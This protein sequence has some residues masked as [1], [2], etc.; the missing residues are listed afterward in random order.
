MRKKYS[1]LLA[2]LFIASFLTAQISGSLYYQ[3][4]YAIK[5]DG[6]TIVGF[7][8]KRNDVHLSKSVNYKETL[9]IDSPTTFLAAD[10]N[11]LY[12]EKGAVKY[13]Q[14]EYLATYNNKTSREKRLAK[15]LLSGYC[16]LYQLEIG[17]KEKPFYF[18]GGSEFVYVVKKDGQWSQLSETE[19][20]EDSQYSLTKEYINSLR[21]LFNDCDAIDEEVIT[22]INFSAQDL[23][24]LFTIYNNCKRNSSQ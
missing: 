4:G 21:T 24:R 18:E 9:S 8:Q 16:N 11:C 14:V 19:K 13:E 15:P 2:C 17:D 3:K 7:F 10:L 22:T 12:F 20:M 5:T 23:I 6:D 1:L